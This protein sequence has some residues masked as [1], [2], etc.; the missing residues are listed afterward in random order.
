MEEV[1]VKRLLE[2]KETLALAESCT[3]GLLAH[4]ITNVPGASGVFLAGYVTYANAAKTNV[5]GLSM[6]W[7]MSRK[8]RSAN[9][10]RAPWRKARAIGR[11]QRM[12]WPRRELPART[13][14]R[15]RS[16]LEQYT[17]P[18]RRRASGDTR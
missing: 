15:R 14:A 4:R 3:G 9:R 18:S 17:S 16:R 5:L 10:W 13:A 11:N 6:H 12:R 7:L 8:A 2:R 1:L